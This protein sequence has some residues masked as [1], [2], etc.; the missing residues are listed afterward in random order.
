LPDFTYHEE[1][2]LTLYAEMLS[3]FL[4][5]AESS[6]GDTIELFATA[7]L[8]TME[9]TAS[10]G[11]LV[12]GLVGSS[13]NKLK[14]QNPTPGLALISN[15]KVLTGDQSVGSALKDAIVPSQFGEAKD[16]MSEALNKD[17]EIPTELK[18]PIHKF[19]FDSNSFAANP[20][21]LAGLG[22]GSSAGAYATYQWFDANRDTNMAR[23]A[24]RALEKFISSTAK[25]TGKS[26]T[27]NRPAT[28]LALKGAATIGDVVDTLTKTPYGNREMLTDFSTINLKHT[29]PLHRLGLNLA[30][31]GGI[32][33]V[34]DQFGKKLY[35]GAKDMF[36]PAARVEIP[37]LIHPP[38]GVDIVE[39]EDDDSDEDKEASNADEPLAKEALSEDTQRLLAG[40]LVKPAL[41][42]AA[43]MIPLAV[44][45]RV[46]GRNLYGGLERIRPDEELNKPRIVIQEADIKE[47]DSP[48]IT[49]EEHKKQEKKASLGEIE[50]VL[51][52]STGKVENAKSKLR[53]YIANNPTGVLAK[54]DK[55]LQKSEYTGPKDL[56]HFVT[57]E[58]P[59]KS[60]ESF[61]YATPM[62]AAGIITGRNMKKG[63]EKLTDNP[64]GPNSQT[65]ILEHSNEKENN[66]TMG[67]DKR[68]SSTEEIDILLDSF[69]FEQNI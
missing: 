32:A 29:S 41:S 3:K 49:S 30:I 67:Q 24:E 26:I 17:L 14:F 21:A 60:V 2:R 23:G 31:I 50:E 53:N 47:D 48:V 25:E 38:V 13:V 10:L 57:E 27:K 45:S 43:F 22:A 39:D 33:A 16:T 44:A 9:R 56:A 46:L 12:T 51:V 58:L 61:A 28:K 8:N 34:E 15:H 59:Y 37:N 66:E 55:L 4:K 65:L 54:S 18:T 69:I 64:G 40:R 68:A 52:H 5:I 7:V 11:G 35:R 36:A 63:F 1:V 62:I 42:T 19:A 6:R 20:Y